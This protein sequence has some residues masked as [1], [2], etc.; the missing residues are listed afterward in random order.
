M[1]G[2]PDG[3]LAPGRGI[4]G[5]MVLLHMAD[6]TAEHPS[7]RTRRVRRANRSGTLLASG[8]HGGPA[9][10]GVPLVGPNPLQGAACA[11]PGMNPRWWDTD[12]PRDTKHLAQKVCAD[13][14]VKGLCPDNIEPRTEA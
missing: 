7:P 1:S 14:P 4:T 11:L 13:C 2:N 10:E 12:R 8:A 6:G 5:G 9:W 3:F